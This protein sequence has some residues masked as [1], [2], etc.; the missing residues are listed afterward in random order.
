MTKNEKERLFELTEQVAYM[1]RILMERKIEL[2]KLRRMYLKTPD[3]QE[4][5]TI[6]HKTIKAE[7][8][9]KQRAEKEL[10]K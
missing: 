9:G 1:E 10:N 6:C 8:E 7:Q 3:L 4:F 2:S 5:E